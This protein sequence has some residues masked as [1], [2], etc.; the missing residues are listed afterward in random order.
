MVTYRVRAR[1]H[2]QLA[3]PYAEMVARFSRQVSELHDQGLRGRA[4]L[5]A[6]GR[7]RGTGPLP[8]GVLY[9]L[10]LGSVVA[11]AATILANLAAELLCLA[12]L[13]DGVAAR[14]WQAWF[15][16][17]SIAAGF[18]LLVVLP[19]LT[20]GPGWRR[21]FASLKSDDYRRAMALIDAAATESADIP[22]K[23]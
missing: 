23:L 6:V 7:L 5:D 20:E 16:L 12:V 15:V 11:V 1:A 13:A 3:G 2:D 9:L 4:L 19:L 22:R 14:A 18:L 21:P 10:R 8:L 17:L